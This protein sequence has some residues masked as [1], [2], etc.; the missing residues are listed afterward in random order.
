MCDPSGLPEAALT[1]FLSEFS[2]NKLLTYSKY[3]QTTSTLT[4]PPGNSRCA[5]NTP[6]QENIDHSLSFP[7]QETPNSHIPLQD[8]SKACQPPTSAA[9][10]YKQREFGD[11]GEKRRLLLVE[12]AAAKGIFLDS[13][14]GKPEN[15]CPSWTGPKTDLTMFKQSS[16][17]SW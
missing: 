7:Q 1:I 15:L 11:G 9:Q 10:T 13:R 16:V 6:S 5:Q 17:A 3:A 12:W 4:H 8:I 14:E 2:E